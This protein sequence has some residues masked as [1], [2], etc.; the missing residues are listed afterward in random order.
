MLESAGDRA[1]QQY[2]SANCRQLNFLK[3]FLVVSRTATA[4]L[5]RLKVLLQ[6]RKISMT[7]FLSSYRNTCE[8]S[9]ELEKA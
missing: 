6:V 8:H 5:D 7:L 4:P 9:G 1:G 3:F 2:S